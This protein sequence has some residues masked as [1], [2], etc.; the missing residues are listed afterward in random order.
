MGFKLKKIF[1]NVVN[2]VS[3]P[4]N[5]LAGATGAIDLITGG[6]TNFFGTTAGIQADKDAQNKQNAWNYNE[7][8]RAEDFQ[9]QMIDAQ[10]NYN[11]PYM[12][13][14]RLVAAGLNPNLIYG[15][16]SAGNQ[17]VIPDAR[18]ASYNA[19]RSAR[20][21]L[22]S[23]AREAVAY[24]SLMRQYQ[25][26]DARLDLDKKRVDLLASM[27]P[28]NQLEKQVLI[29]KLIQDQELRNLSMKGVANFALKK[30]N[31]YRNNNGLKNTS[32]NRNLLN[33]IGI[34][35]TL[36]KSLSN[37]IGGFYRNFLTK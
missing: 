26:E 17:S 21:L 8:R 30:I 34:F 25:L 36:F 15:Q 27:T 35:K 16:V 7:A 6:K 10:N 9:R 3:D 20:H 28:L 12:Q 33:S 23:I 24:Q 1:K 19:P 2:A 22:S 37:H 31:E 5:L 29:N 11:S 4:K 14:Q 13:M 18:V 32:T